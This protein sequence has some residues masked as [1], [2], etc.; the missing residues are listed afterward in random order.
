MC[1]A[2]RKWH[3]LTGSCVE[4]RSGGRVVRTGEVDTVVV[5]SSVAWLK[6]TATTAGS[7]LPPRTASLL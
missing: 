4:L 6:S 1:E 5:D 7:R 2:T 3:R